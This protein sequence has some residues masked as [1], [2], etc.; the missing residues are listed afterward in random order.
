VLHEILTHRDNCWLVPPADDD[1]WFQAI[2]QLRADSG[3]R[4]SLGAAARKAFIARH[5]WN[6]RAAAILAECI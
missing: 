4:A 6:Q 2:A 1:A 5:T 3:L